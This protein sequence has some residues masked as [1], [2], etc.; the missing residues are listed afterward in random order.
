ML[1]STTRERN[2]VGRELGIENNVTLCGWV[3]DTESIYADLD[4]LVCSSL[5]EGTSVSVI[6]AL[7]AG[8]PVVSTN[9]G[10]MSDVLSK[11]EYGKLVPSE[12]ASE[13]AKA[14]IQVIGSS[15]NRSDNIKYRIVEKYSV[16]RLCSDMDGL[17]RKLLAGIV[18]H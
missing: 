13:L 16:S 10:G 18:D 6:E 3:R 11:G 5:N 8:V 15:D 4:V 7:A 12:D 1:L 2:I 17:Y 9:V 14:A